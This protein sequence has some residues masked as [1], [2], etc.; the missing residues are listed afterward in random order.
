MFFVSKN[1]LCKT[2]ENCPNCPNYPN[3]E[4]KKMRKQKKSVLNDSQ[5]FSALEEWI[6]KTDRPPETISLREKHGQ[7]HE[8]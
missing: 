4:G 1:L 6:E 7:A 8:P 3:F 5:D 2:L